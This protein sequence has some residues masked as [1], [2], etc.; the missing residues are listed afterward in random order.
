M[1]DQTIPL[2][3]PATTADVAGV[4][5]TVLGM[6]VAF[7]DLQIAMSFIGLILGALGLYV[8]IKFHRIADQRRRREIQL[9]EIELGVRRKEDYA[10]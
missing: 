1:N 10:P 7:A 5:T 8:T 6:T 2:P 3:P 9:K 4:S